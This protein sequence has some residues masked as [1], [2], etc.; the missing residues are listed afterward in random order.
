MQIGVIKQALTPFLLAYSSILRAKHCSLIGPIIAHLLVRS[1]LTCQCEPLLNLRDCVQAANLF[2]KIDPIS[3][4]NRIRIEDGDEVKTVVR[5][6]SVPSC[7]Q[8]ILKCCGG[9]VGMLHAFVG[10]L[11]TRPMIE[12][13]PNHPLWC[14]G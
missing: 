7:G 1:L 12:H 14:R 3:G 10:V 5:T 6:Q 2:M 13:I 9:S 4:C 8:G 11:K